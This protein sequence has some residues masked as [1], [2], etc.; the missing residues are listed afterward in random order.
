MYCKY[1]GAELEDG[2]AV[3]PSCG[4]TLQQAEEPAGELLE[5][6]AVTEPAEEPA[7]EA[8]AQEPAEEPAAQPVRGYEEASQSAYGTYQQPA[9]APQAQ[10]EQTNVL[11]ILGLVFAFLF[12][13][14]GLILSILG[15][16]K[17]AEM[18]GSGESLAK[19]GLIISIIL[20]VIEV[21]SGIIAFVGPL[22]FG[23]F[24]MLLGAGA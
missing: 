14:V 13:L 19:A 24:G 5:E 12:P 2:T 4:A 6:A 7:D 9:A 11:A 10:P 23:L 20:L 21:G 15:K 18:G 8:P 22:A 3:C 1:C 17:A 16:K